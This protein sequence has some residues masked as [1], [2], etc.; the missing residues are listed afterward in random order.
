[1]PGCSTAAHGTG[2]KERSLWSQ[3]RIAI[4]L[5][6]CALHAKL[7]VLQAVLQAKTFVTALPCFPTVSVPDRGACVGMASV[8]VRTRL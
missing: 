5:A 6:T 4:Y 2:R 8:A 1:M 3:V 7:F